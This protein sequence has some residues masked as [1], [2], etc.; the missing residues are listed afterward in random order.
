MIVVRQ[1][2]GRRRIH[3]TS[4]ES[5]SG[6]IRKKLTAKTSWYKGSRRKDDKMEG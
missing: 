5:S 1:V 2:D 3:Q 4:E 6:R